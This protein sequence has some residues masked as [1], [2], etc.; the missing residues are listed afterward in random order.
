MALRFIDEKKGIARLK[1]Q[2]QDNSLTVLIIVLIFILVSISLIAFFISY[3]KSFNSQTDY[4]LEGLEKVSLED[5]LPPSN[6]E[7]KTPVKEIKED[8]YE[9]VIVHVDG[10]VKNP[11]VFQLNSSKRI[12]DA[13]M[14]AGGL[15]EEAQT[16]A[17]NLASKLSDGSK[18]YIPS[19][20]ESQSAQ[21]E[22]A[23]DAP[24]VPQDSQ[25]ASG[26]ININQAGIDELSTIPGVGPKT[27]QAIIDERKKGAYSSIEDICRVSGIGEKK[28][29]KMKEH[30]CV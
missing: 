30:I 27:A 16:K 6:E 21:T 3:N 28:F 25:G 17:V 14:A 5:T 10:A 2:I 9:L 11:G 22:I 15:T 12:Q 13:V 8:V 1:E 7:S 18:I 29:S 26:K 24:L 23:F 4:E 20:D 19:M